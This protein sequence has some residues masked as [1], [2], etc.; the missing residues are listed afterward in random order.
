MQPLVVL[1]VL[2]LSTLILLPIS[3]LI[4]QLPD[5]RR[6]FRL[7]VQARLYFLGCCLIPTLAEA[8]LMVVSCYWYKPVDF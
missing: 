5:L 4:Q 2:V 8:G 7:Q 3:Q 1:A 6:L